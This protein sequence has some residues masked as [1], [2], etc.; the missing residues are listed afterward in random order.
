LI[1]LLLLFQIFFLAQS[2]VTILLLLFLPAYW[3]FFFPRPSAILGV[4]CFLALAALA[5]VYMLPQVQGLRVA[6]LAANLLAHPLDL[7]RIDVSVNARIGHI[8]F[9]ILGFL[10]NHGIPG[11][12][13]HFNTYVGFKASKVNFVWLGGLSP[14][15][16]IISG[17]GAGLF[18]LG[19]FGLAIPLAGLIACLNFFRPELR[20]GLVFGAF[21]TTIMFSGNPVSLP[22]FGLFLGYLMAGSQRQSSSKSEAKSALIPNRIQ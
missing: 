18:E 19:I 3:F 14:H 4:L 22:C 17:Y 9:S 2:G 21:L 13:D 6:Y 12:F 15:M 7:S 1:L 11:G 10:D 16:K 20:K 8:L 5:F